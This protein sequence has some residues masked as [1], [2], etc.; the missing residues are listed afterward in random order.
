MDRECQAKSVCEL[1]RHRSEF[2][3]R[4]LD[5]SL[6]LADVVQYFN[7]PDE[8]HNALDE[9]QVSYLTTF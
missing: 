5:H 4:A 7:L 2:Q 3:S 6:G 8:I 9:F 1:V